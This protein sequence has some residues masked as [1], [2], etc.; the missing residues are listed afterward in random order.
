MFAGAGVNM[1]AIN[2][3]VVARG[4]VDGGAPVSLYQRTI[5]LEPN[6]SYVLS[7]YLWNMGDGV[8]HVT[9]VVDMNDV[10][11]EPQLTL[12]SSP[13]DADQGYFVYQTFNTSDTGTSVTLRA[14]YDG[15]SGTGTA[16]SYFPISAQWDNLAITK[17][18]NFVPP[19]DA[20]SGGNIRP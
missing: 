20:G 17:E 6:T 3:S 16:P 13:G 12:Y 5:N 11:G 15:F 2:A 19:Q 9:T 18:A 4:Q 14:F 8:N 10:S 1:A 7:A